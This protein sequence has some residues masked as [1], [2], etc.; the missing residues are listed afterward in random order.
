MGLDQRYCNTLV[1]YVDAA[2]TESFSPRVTLTKSR[3][4]TPIYSVARQNGEVLTPP[5][6][7][8]LNHHRLFLR[9]LLRKGGLGATILSLNARLACRKVV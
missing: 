4:F 6:G 7:G 5:V 2:K 1:K 3:P 8:Y 9:S